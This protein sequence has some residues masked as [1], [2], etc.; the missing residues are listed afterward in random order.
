[1]VE[2]TDHAGPRATVLSAD[3]GNPAMARARYKVRPLALRLWEE[4]ADFPHLLTDVVDA[5]EALPPEQVEVTK[6]MRPPGVIHE[7][8][9]VA[10]GRRF[11]VRGVQDA[12]RQWI[13]VWSVTPL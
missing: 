3:P 6:Q 4:F 8:S 10:F 13:E 2:T 12:D 1:M 7:V 5:I 9:G 11:K